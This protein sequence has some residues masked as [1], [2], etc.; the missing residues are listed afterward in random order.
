VAHRAVVQQEIPT[1]IRELRIRPLDDA[2]AEEVG[3]VD[4]FVC[5]RVELGQDTCTALPSGRDTAPVE[6]D[7]LVRLLTLRIP[8][9]EAHGLE[10]VA[11]EVVLRIDTERTEVARAFP[12]RVGSE[13]PIR[14]VRVGGRCRAWE[15]TGPTQIGR[16]SCREGGGRWGRGGAYT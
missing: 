8:S 9:A 4:Q 6:P 16:A 10:P 2:A 7:F 1:D 11:V 3:E 12:E 13:L 14:A 5:R 15:R